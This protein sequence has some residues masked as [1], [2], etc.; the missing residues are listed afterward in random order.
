[1]K[2]SD[3]YQL[4][5]ER[6][7]SVSDNVAH[8]VRNLLLSVLNQTGNTL[9]PFLDYTLSQNELKCFESFLKDSESGKPL[10]YILGYAHFGFNRYIVSP[11]VL[12]PRPDTEILVE[13]A[14][15][16]LRTHSSTDL[17]IIEIGLGSGIIS[18]ELAYRFPDLH[19]HGWEIDPET[20][21]ISLK[22][23]SQIAP[24]N[25]TF[26][27]NDFFHDQSTWEPLIHGP[28]LLLSNPPYIPTSEL[29]SLDSNVVDFEPTLALDGGMDGLSFYRQILSTF[30]TFS[31]ISTFLEIG[32]NQQKLITDLSEQFHWSFQKCFTDLAD[33]DR[34]LWFTR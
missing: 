34:V 20:F 11:N 3:C 15:D 29:N 21:S 12:I 18:L 1:M 17:T 22:N 9:T 13:S 26:Y 7:S 10:A 30:S 8:D 24:S 6:L 27:C 14:S 31:H 25:T 19:F 2:I 16:W 4:G 28:V 23:Q 32:F 33:R 5:V